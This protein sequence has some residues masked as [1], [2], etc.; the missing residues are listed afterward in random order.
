[1]VFKKG[2]SEASTCGRKGGS[3][4]GGGRYL[5]K[6]NQNREHQSRA[7]KMSRYW[8]QLA[9]S[10]LVKDY[11]K[12]FKPFRVC[13]RICIKDGEIIFVEVKRKRNGKKEKLRPL[14]E[15]FKNLCEKLGYRYEIIYISGK[16]K[17]AKGVKTTEYEL[18]LVER[19]K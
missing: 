5:K 12:I 18:N 3:K 17:T 19:F 2:D 13:D 4:G 14:Q 6:V 15:E 1:M 11:D 16:R 7:G 8:E 9:I 10:R